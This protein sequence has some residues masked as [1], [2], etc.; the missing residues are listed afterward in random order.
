MENFAN[1]V[2]LI[3]STENYREDRSENWGEIDDS[4]G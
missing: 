4:K 1:G 2:C 3:V